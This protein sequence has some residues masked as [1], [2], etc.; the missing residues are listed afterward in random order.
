MFKPTPEKNSFTTQNKSK[1][2]K[3]HK[4]LLI[5]KSKLYNNIQ[6]QWSKPLNCICYA[7]PHKKS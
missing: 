6:G 7:A 3:F 4:N 1:E 5:E 2:S